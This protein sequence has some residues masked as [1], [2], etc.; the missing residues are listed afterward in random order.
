[1]E[2]ANF[3]F[4]R[5]L[6]VEDDLLNQKLMKRYMKKLNL[7]GDIA[8]NGQIALEM[9]KQQQYVLVLLDI[10]MPIMDGIETIRR[11]RN[12]DD[13]KDFRNIYVIALTAHAMRGDRE[14][15]L[16]VGCNDYAAKPINQDE[17]SS[18]IFKALK[19][20]SVD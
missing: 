1:M 11:I 20:V 2:A 8:S 13:C 17:L 10:Q 19:S 16:S 6:V 12:D 14:K 4:G 7:I 3:G 5:I 18:K 9:L 15:Y